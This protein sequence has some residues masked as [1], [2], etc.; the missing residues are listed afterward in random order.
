MGEDTYIHFN[1][2]P[3]WATRRIV[4]FRPNDATTWVQSDPVPALNNKTFIE[5]MN[6]GEEGSLQAR[7][8]LNDV[9]SRFFPRYMISWGKLDYSLC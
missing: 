7:K 5:V 1:E 3:E 8:Y 6:Q 9:L 4:V 2:L